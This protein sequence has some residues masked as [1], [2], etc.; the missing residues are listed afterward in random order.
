MYESFRSHCVQDYPQYEIVFGVSEADDPAIQLVERLKAEF[1]ERG[2]RLVFCGKSLGANT[3][4]SNLA[5]MLPEAQYEHLVVNDSDIRVEPDYLRSVV[6]PLASPKIGLVTCLYRG[7]A[8]RTFASRLESLASARIFAREFS[9]R[10]K[11]RAGFASG[12]GLPLP[13]GAPIWRPLAASRESPIIWRTITRSGVASAILAGRCSFRARSSRPSFP[14]YSLRQAFQHQLRWA[15]TI[16]DS[17]RWG[18][19]G[20][21]VTFGIPWALLGGDLLLGIGVGVAV[22][23]RGGGDAGGRGVGGGAKGSRRSSGSA[24]GC[25]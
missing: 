16:R 1:P 23:R 13:S 10:G 17:R 24:S 3:K 21:V 18:Y 4:V 15:R 7:V 6:A 9:W 8:A 25:G 11:L 22:A 5:Q 12:W 2:I 14:A 19:A 20:L